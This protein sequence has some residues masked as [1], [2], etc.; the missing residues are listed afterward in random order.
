MP[1]KA[2]P[3]EPDSTVNIKYKKEKRGYQ[4]TSSF[5]MQPGHSPIYFKHHT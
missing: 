5:F 2:T 4:M 1:S 3:G